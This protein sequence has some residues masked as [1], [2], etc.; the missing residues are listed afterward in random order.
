ML[1]RK[2]IPTNISNSNQG[3]LYKR[4]QNEAQEN[5]QGNRRYHNKKSVSAI[6]SND[7]REEED[8]HDAFTALH[9]QAIERTQEERNEAF[10][11]IE[12]GLPEIRR[13]VFLT[14]K[15]DTGA[16]ANTMPLRAYKQLYPAKILTN[17]DPDPSFLKQK[18]TR[19]IAYN[20]TQI[21]QFGIINI[22]AKYKSKWI[23]SEFFVVEDYGP[24][25]LG[26]SLDICIAEL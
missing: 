22:P 11:E 16:Q 4:V 12:L 6:E 26:L 13:R 5:K 2:V 17:G 19:L 21:K 9:I 18:N 20:K 8:P 14:A 23:N 10:V 1:S 7:D 25:I 15:V 24:A 3:Q